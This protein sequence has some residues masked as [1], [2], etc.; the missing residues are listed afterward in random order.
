MLDFRAQTSNFCIIR[1]TTE[2]PI[3][4]LMQVAMVTIMMATGRRDDWCRITLTGATKLDE[5]WLRR[6]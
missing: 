6:R 2:T 1:T 5:S 4:L 3:S